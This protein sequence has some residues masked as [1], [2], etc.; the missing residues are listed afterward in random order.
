M[1]VAAAIGRIDAA[2][3]LANGFLQRQIDRR[4]R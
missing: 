4:E 3:G 2:K 1:S